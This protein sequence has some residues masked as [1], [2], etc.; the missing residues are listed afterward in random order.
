M[1][2]MVPMMVEILGGLKTGETEGELRAVVEDFIWRLT[3]QET[4]YQTMEL[5]DQVEVRGGTPLDPRWPTN[6]IYLDGGPS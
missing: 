6:V 2:V 5:G 1:Q 4:V 3:G